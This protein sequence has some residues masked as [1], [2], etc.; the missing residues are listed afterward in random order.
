MAT[1]LSIG[2]LAGRYTLDGQSDLIQLVDPGG[3]ALLSINNGGKFTNYAGLPLVNSG[4]P[5]QVASF[6]AVNQGAAITSQ[7]LYTTQQTDVGQTGDFFNAFYSAKVVQAATS[8]STLG[9]TSGITFNYTSGDDGKSLSSIP[10][11]LNGNVG[12]ND[13]TTTVGTGAFTLYAKSGST[14]QFNFDYL[15]SGITPML[16]DIHV[17][18]FRV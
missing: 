10:G 7:F 15:S 18:L 11:V 9:G 3:A 13:L 4:V 17:R 16:Y 1:S 6:D 2:A 12:H 8:S 5:S 14:I